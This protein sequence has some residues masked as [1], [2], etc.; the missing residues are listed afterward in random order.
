MVQSRKTDHV[1]DFFFT[2]SSMS[3]ILV[4]RLQ[5]Y[6]KLADNILISLIKQV[7][8]YKTINIATAERILKAGY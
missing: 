6:N 5:Y 4:L 8:S 7:V 2:S 3:L 1:E